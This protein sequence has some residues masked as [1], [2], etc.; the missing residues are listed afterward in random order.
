MAE[1]PERA[2]G[3]QP[4]HADSQVREIVS[5]ITAVADARLTEIAG[6]I[7]TRLVGEIEYFATDQPILDQLNA[8]AAD[9]FAITMAILRHDIEIEAVGPSAPAT[10]LARLLA[11][12]D[13][14][15]TALEHAYRL[16]QDSVVRWCLQ[17]LALRSESATVTAGAALEITTLVSAHVN[18]IAQQL[19]STY[20]F[21]RDAWRLRRSASRSARINDLLANRHIEV[22]PTERILGYHLGQYHLGIIMWTDRAQSPEVGLAHLESAA[23][24][25]ACQ[26]GTSAPPLFEARDEHMARAWVPLGDAD[27]V[28]SERLSAVK[29]RWDSPVIVAIGQ[30]R[31]GVEGFVRT[32]TEADLARVVVQAS[33]SPGPGI[34][35]AG[36]LGAVMLMCNDLSAT[37]AWVADILG[38]LGV[39]DTAAAQL[40]AT[41]R[42]FLRTGGSYAAAADA[43]H[44]HKNS[45]AYRLKKIE[46]QLGRSVRDHRLN[47]EIALELAFWLGSAVL[48]Q[49]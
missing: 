37:R 38:P 16:Y 29:R 2:E 9:N 30:P 12:R 25:L 40:R 10:E 22:E 45:V 6:A 3:G 13:I 11:Q 48:T 35:C 8:G 5:A 42:E 18:L 24:A 19:L 31:E 7:V 39:D 41:L 20:E 47:L 23:T 1:L 34:V 46:D 15:I 17:E 28:D 27:T 36:D 21:E 33:E 44:M 4:D 26:L 32:H 14:P 49:D 43:L